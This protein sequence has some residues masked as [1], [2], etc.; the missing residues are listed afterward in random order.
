MKA[1]FVGSD[2]NS[3]S[4]EVDPEIA[5][6]TCCGVDYVKHSHT[7]VSGTYFIV[8]VADVPADRV[9]AERIASAKEAFVANPV[10]HT[11]LSN[12]AFYLSED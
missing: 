9:V 3:T 2:L 7:E 8:M 6:V 10:I 12:F 5:K 4:T 11:D 1:L